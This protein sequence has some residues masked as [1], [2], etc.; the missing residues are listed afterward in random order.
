MVR[1]DAPYILSAL[2]LIALLF[3]KPQAGIHN[4]WI[5]PGAA[6]FGNFF[7]SLLYRQGFPVTSQGCQIIESIG[8]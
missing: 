4:P 7:Q 8:L 6:L 1:Q 3:E 5:E 2:N